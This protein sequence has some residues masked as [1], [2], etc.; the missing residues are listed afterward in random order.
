MCVVECDGHGRRSGDDAKSSP[1]Q[2]KTVYTARDVTAHT[3]TK[4]VVRRVLLLLRP[5]NSALRSRFTR[6]RRVRV[7]SRTIWSPRTKTRPKSHVSSRTADS[8]FWGVFVAP[9][10]AA[11]NG[12]RPAISCGCREHAEDYAGAPE[13]FG[14][15]LIRLRLTNRKTFTWCREARCA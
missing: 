1:Q 5:R 15:N 2:Y 6:L 3:H 13:S 14:I 11:A 4:T 9:R 7:R 10:A 8:R 12:K